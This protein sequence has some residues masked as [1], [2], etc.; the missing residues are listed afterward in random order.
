MEIGWFVQLELIIQT[1]D[2]ICEYLHGQ[3][4]YTRNSEYVLPPVRH[5]TFRERLSA[6]GTKGSVAGIPQT[7]DNEALLVQATVNHAG[8]DARACSQ[9]LIV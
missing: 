9:A 4:K 5:T 6:D 2:K 3:S 1:L 8:I 7:W